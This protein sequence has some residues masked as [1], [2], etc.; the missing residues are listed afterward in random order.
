MRRLGHSW[1]DGGY[2]KLRQVTEVKS[3]CSWV[4]LSAS[5]IHVFL[6]VSYGLTRIKH[7]LLWKGIHLPSSSVSIP[8]NPWP[9]KGESRPVEGRSLRSILETQACL[10]AKVNSRALSSPAVIDCLN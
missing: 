6:G 10:C 1:K 8:V 3:S 5:I 7:G 9:T 2:R 4:F